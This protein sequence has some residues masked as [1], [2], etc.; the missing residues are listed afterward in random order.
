MRGTG[1]SMEEEREDQEEEGEGTPA[2]RTEKEVP[3]CRLSTLQLV[4]VWKE[5]E[6]AKIALV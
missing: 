3:A 1:D 5:K 4:Q 2:A 6:A